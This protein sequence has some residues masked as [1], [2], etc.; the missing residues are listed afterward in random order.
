[1][2]EGRLWSK[3]PMFALPVAATAIL[4]QLFSASDVAVVGNFTGAASTAS[5]AAVGANTPISGLIVNLFI[6]VALGANVV[7]AQA[8]GRR[9]QATVDRAVHTAVLMALIAGLMVAIIGEILAAPFLTL[10]KVPEDVFSLALLYLRIYLLGM[11]VILLYNFESAIF[12]SV[13][14]TRMPLLALTFSGVVNVLLNLFFV[15]VLHRTVDGVAMATVIANGI[16]AA[17]LFRRLTTTHL[18][19]RMTP[20]RLRIDWQVLGQILR[21]GLPAGV[22]GAMFGISN[23]VV[24]SAI[25]ALGVVAMAASSA[26]FYIEVITFDILNAFGQ[27]CTTFVGQNYGAGQYQRCRRVMLLCIAEAA[28]AIAFV[29][30]L[31]VVFGKPMLSIFNDTPAVIALGYI[32]LMVIMPAHFFSMVYEVLSGYLRGFGISLVPA[33][34]TVIGVCGLRVAWVQL[35]L[36]LA[37]NFTTL[38]IVYPVTLLTT[39]IFLIIATCVFHP[40]RKLEKA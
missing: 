25:N 30:A 35:V 5:V 29:L 7:V 27:A 32:R 24:Q 11:P 36:P 13:G 39:A 34:L 1:M 6:G 14:E 16:S 9:D 31:V 17:I 26:A 10:L 8:L 20:R 18:P 22:Q 12:R 3:L 33:I 2:L 21:I 4:E 40:V 19:I 23:L 28:L 37:P 15:I 38:M